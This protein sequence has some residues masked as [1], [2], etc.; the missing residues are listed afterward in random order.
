MKIESRSLRS[1]LYSFDGI[2]EHESW[3]T[4]LDIVLQ[5]DHTKNITKS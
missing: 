5:P 2:P 3:M 4:S 1:G